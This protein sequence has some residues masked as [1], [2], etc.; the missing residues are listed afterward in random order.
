MSTILAPWTDEQVNLLKK[1]QKICHPYTC[2]GG[3]GPHHVDLIPTNEGWTCPECDR[4]VQIDCTSE[5]FEL[6]ESAQKSSNWWIKR[7]LS[8]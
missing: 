6:V 5:D 3:G 1:C 4:V 7:K 2:S 8:I